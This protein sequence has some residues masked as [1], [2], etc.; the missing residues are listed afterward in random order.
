MTIV[1]TS[2]QQQW[3]IIEPMNRHYEV[4]DQAEVDGITWYTV[5]CSK[6]VGN[7]VR[8]QPED[9]WV[10]HI[11]KGWLFHVNN[12]DMHKELFALL[13]LSWSEYGNYS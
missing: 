13:K 10:N 1:K 9:Q 2:V 8:E 7:W 6:E 4:L 12:F 3:T 11:N 5:K